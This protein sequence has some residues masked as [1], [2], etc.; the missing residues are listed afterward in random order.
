MTLTE[1]SLLP[2]G[3]FPQHPPNHHFMQTNMHFSSK[4]RGI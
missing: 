4:D 1:F 3:T 2:K